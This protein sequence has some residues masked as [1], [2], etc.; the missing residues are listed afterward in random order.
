MRAAQYAVVRYIA[1][2]GRREEVNVGLVVWDEADCLVTIDPAAAQQVI[3]DA[4]WLER[5]SMR[6]LEPQI[7][8]E[9]ER[10]LEFAPSPDMGMRRL[11]EQQR[12]YPVRLTEPRITSVLDG[13]GLGDTRDRLLK[14][15]V[16]PR[17]RPGGGG[18]TPID[19]VERKLRTLIRQH[20]V[21]EDYSFSESKS[22]VPRSVHFFANSTNNVA[23]DAVQ[24]AVQSADDIIQRAD[25]EANKIA[26]IRAENN[27]E[28]WTYCRL[29]DRD[30]LSDAYSKAF[31]IISA[32]GAQ[33]FTNADEAAERFKDRIGAS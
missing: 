2:P 25:A 17:R 3:R 13:Q 4:P 30:E 26:D 21:Y 9:V 24:L 12:G 33:V 18:P 16:A 11:I 5:D 20:K 15:L 7:Q 23:L 6:S 1:D 14:R 32:A 22:G 31:A 28:F 19:E 10:A 8:G 27:I 29:L